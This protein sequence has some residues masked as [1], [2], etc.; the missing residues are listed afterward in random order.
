MQRKFFPEV[1]QSE[2][3]R[4]SIE[5]CQ[6]ALSIL[7][8]QLEANGY[9]TIQDVLYQAQRIVEAASLTDTN[10]HN[11]MIVKKSEIA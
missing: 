2:A 4:V 9:I 11:L 7:K 10:L 8:R 1:P 5:G 6:Q 3:T